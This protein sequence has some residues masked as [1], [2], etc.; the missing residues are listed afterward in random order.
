MIQVKVVD[1]I[2]NTHFMFN[3][4]FSPENRALYETISKNTVQKDRL[5]HHHHYH[6][7]HHH[8]LYSPGWASA[9]SARQVTHDN[10]AHVLCVLD[11]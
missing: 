2:K 11:N 5:S 3:N 1:K 9:S 8:R 10:K 7:H 4:F 6:H